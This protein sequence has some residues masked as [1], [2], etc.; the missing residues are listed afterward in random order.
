M[1][2]DVV[3]LEDTTDAIPQCPGRSD[4][5]DLVGKLPAPGQFPGEPDRAAQGAHAGDQQIGAGGQ[6]GGFFTGG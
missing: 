5:D 3:D 6:V 4:V 1:L 2:V